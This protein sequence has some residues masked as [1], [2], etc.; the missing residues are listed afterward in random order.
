MDT[1]GLQQELAEAKQQIAELKTK[2]AT[3]D[4]SD[5]ALLEL[6][7]DSAPGGMAIVT[8]EGDILACNQ[9][10]PKMLGYSSEQIEELNTSDLY[11]DLAD[12]ARLRERLI[13]GDPIRDYEVCLKHL[14]GAKVWTS[15]NA[16]P[17]RFNDKDCALI[18]FVNITTLREAKERLR[19]DEMRFEAL[20]SLSEMMIEPEDV[21]LDFALEIGV[22]VTK[23]E[24]G[25]IYFLSD[26]ETELT[27]HAW[28]KS[29]MPQ[30]SIQD[31]PDAYKVSETGLW[32]E[33]VR[34]RKPIITNDYA[35]SPLKR[36][37]PKGH[38]PVQRHMNIPIMDEDKIVLLAG[39]GNKDTDYNEGD[40]RQLE[41]V[42]RG[43]WRI[44]QRKRAEEQLTKAHEEL[45]E[46]VQE[47]TAKIEKVNEELGILNI[48]L[49]KKDREREQAQRA[50]KES[51]E[52]F[53]T[54]FKNDHAIMLLINPGTGQIVDANP[55]A[56]SY[57]GY[58][59]KTL[60][61]MRISDINTLSTAEVKAEMQNAKEQERNLFF[62]KHRLA[63]GTIRD[64]EVSS[65]PVKINDD[66]LLFSIIHDIT[67]RRKAEETLQRYARIIASTPDLISLVDRNY[68][69]RMVNDAYLDT[70][71]KKHDEIVGESLENILGK[72]FFE[73]T[74]KPNL[75]QAFAGKAVQVEVSLDLPNRKTTH[76]L[77]TYH[78]VTSIDGT[79]DYVS[80]N[81]RDVT[82]RKENEKA[83]KQFADR[84][85]LATDA[86][87]VGIWEWNVETDN[88]IWDEMMLQLYKVDPA[89]FSAMY[90]A[91][92][93]RIHPDDLAEAEQA[94]Q[95]S[96][97]QNKPLDTEFRI[98]WPD[99]EIRH[100]KAAALV[101]FADGKAKRMTG[102]NLDVTQTRKLEEE[103]RTLATT[104]PL[105]GAYNRRR[106]IERAEAEIARGKRYESPVSMLTLDIDHFKKINDTHGHPVG[107]E[108]LKALVDICQHTLR[109]TDIFARMGGEEFSAILPETDIEDAGK[110]AER[111]RRAVERSKVITDGGTITYTISIG[112]SQA[113]DN[114]ES[115]PDLMRRADDALYR[116]KESGRNRVEVE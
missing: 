11:F 67:D 34:Q 23:S 30:C 71:G 41:L 33:A 65:G 64:V 115:L 107:D 24:I 60:R 17:I 52:R 44:I 32:G 91:W 81:A 13:Q 4:S 53:R 47:R 73:A 74:S 22:K 92:R 9:E 5:Q 87:K 76:F 93:S 27:L 19:L 77:S 66:Q 80:I 21:I 83:L 8:L 96:L 70:F 20:Y 90:D 15:I 51:E 38:V 55:A 56:V 40:I 3:C 28:S 106:F 10:G 69:Y 110:T 59:A 104:D 100:I 116:A 88:L 12:K 63:D 99:G 29:V 7:F 6:V 89:Q 95:D 101:E 35:N 105:T 50:L 85:E 57:Y 36:G 2:L 98:I 75:D 58:P 26:D 48:Q 109:T 31:Y 94:M 62:F 102:V 16:R 84:L 112:L 111:L 49:V 54:I 108:V 79:I 18:S 14:N 43:M 114:E 61:A 86:G 113:H 45:E 42:M 78:P 1:K 103:L 72:E 37:Y 82:V 68:T 39:V 25:Y 97:T 46:K